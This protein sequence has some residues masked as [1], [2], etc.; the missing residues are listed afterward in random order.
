MSMRSSTIRFGSRWSAI[1]FV[2][3]LGLAAGACSDGSRNLTGPSAT[4][5]AQAKPPTA[6]VSGA[7]TT[8]VGFESFD[9]ATLSVTVKTTTSSLI[10]QPYIDEGKIQLQILVDAG[11]N[12]VPCDTAGATFVRF[13]T[14]TNGGQNPSAGITTHVVDLD[15]LAS[16]DKGVNNASCGQTICVRA[17]YVTGGGSTKVDTHESEPVSFP[18]PCP[19]CTYTQGY[20]KTHGPVPTGNNDNEWPASVLSGGMLLGTVNYPAAQLQSIFD[21]PVAGNGLI[22]LAH[23]LITAK[24]NIANGASA[25]TAV[26]D[27]I[28]AADA[29]I[30]TLVVPPG[31]SGYLAPSATSALTTTLDN[32]NNGLIGPGHCGS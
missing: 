19:Q 29:L 8:T 23:Q 17:H 31:G 21:T 7:G 3:T 1:P 9:A 2:L 14:F 26:T 6:A 12:P 10:G 13:D 24:L 28:A 4:G 16:R 18:I 15:D 32:Y 25:P 30:G 20:W 5:G 11:G 22:S 27:A